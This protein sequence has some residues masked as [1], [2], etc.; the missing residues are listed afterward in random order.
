MQTKRETVIL[1]LLCFIDDMTVVHKSVYEQT[2][3]ADSIACISK[4]IL[5]ISVI[6]TYNLRNM[7]RVDPW[8]SPK[9]DAISFDNFK[10]F[11]LC[12]LF[13][14]QIQKASTPL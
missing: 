2:R 14:V 12:V 1:W 6:H 11:Q 5:N 10:R 3:F 13:L 8:Q 7:Y 9:D 4:G